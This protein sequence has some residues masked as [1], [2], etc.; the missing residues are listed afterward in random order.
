MRRS[1][2][3]DSGNTN[4]P[5]AALIRQAAADTQNGRRGSKPPSRPP[6]AGPSTKPRPKP[7][8]T[9]PNDLARSSGLVTSAM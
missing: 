7:M 1:G 6:I 2:G 5:N 9:M 4:Q 8:P 3:S